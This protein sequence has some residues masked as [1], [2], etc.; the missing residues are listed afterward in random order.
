MCCQNCLVFLFRSVC[1]RVC[2]VYFDSRFVVCL[3]LLLFDILL[4]S[5]V[6]L[7][8]L[9]RTIGRQ[10]LQMIGATTSCK[11]RGRPRKSPD[12]HN[13]S[14]VFSNYDT[15][16]TASTRIYAD[17]ETADSQDGSTVTIE[18][19]TAGNDD[20]TTAQSLAGNVKN[21]M[22]ARSEELHTALAKRK[23]AQVTRA[24]ARALVH[25]C[26]LCMW[27]LLTYDRL[28]IFG[29]TPS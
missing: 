14:K 18:M 21:N 23:K 9:T 15:A 29:N 20:A 2:I 3:I 10:N 19:T 22:D 26:T 1:V 11:R 13:V 25:S 7:K 4:S 12:K 6:F 17:A 24:R 16:A 27:L 8:T 5:L 28:K